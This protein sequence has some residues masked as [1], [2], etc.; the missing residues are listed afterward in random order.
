MDK[1]V[2]VRRIGVSILVA[3][4]ALFAS[5]AAHADPHNSFRAVNH[6]PAMHASHMASWNAG[7]RGMT[8]PSHP[9][10]FHMRD[11]RGGVTTVKVGATSG[12]SRAMPA[13]SGGTHAD[14]R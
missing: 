11:I 10:V 5:S 8:P 7:F 2:A 3:G 1:L 14:S 6:M 12:G 4:S 9:V 13:T